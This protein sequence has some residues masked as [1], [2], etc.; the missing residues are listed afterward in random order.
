MAGGGGQA[1]RAERKGCGVRRCLG[2][3]KIPLG[4][5]VEKYQV[6][7]RRRERYLLQQ[8]AARR[9]GLEGVGIGS[10]VR[11]GCCAPAG[12]QALELQPE[13]PSLVLPSLCARVP[14]PQPRASQ[15]E[16]PSLC[17]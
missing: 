10:P 16:P 9:P 17:A 7:R 14:A 4:G 13:R 15:L 1:R 8:P 2:N 6:T 5:R 11:A 3:G 12:A